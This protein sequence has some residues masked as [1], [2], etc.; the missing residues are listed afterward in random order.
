MY[1]INMYA[2]NDPTKLLTK[3]VD[4]RNFNYCNDRP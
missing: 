2:F 1:V 3:N 4:T